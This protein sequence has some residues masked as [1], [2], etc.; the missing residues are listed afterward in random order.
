MVKK[1]DN[2]ELL[3]AKLETSS[4]SMD[5]GRKLGYS[6]LD[7]PKKLEDHFY[8]VAAF[9]LPYY[10]VTG[11]KTD[12]YRIRYLE[13]TK[14]GIFKQTNLKDRRYDQPSAEIPQLYIP[15]IL[16]KGKTWKDI[17]E[18]P[19]IPVIFTEGELKAACATKHGLPTLA[20]GGVWNF[21]SK[22]AGLLRLPI[23]NEM[24]FKGRTVFI[25][26]D[27]DSATNPQVLH[28]QYKFAEEIFAL[29]AN[30]VVV[31]IPKVADKKHGID[32]YIVEYGLDE[33]K[34][35]LTDDSNHTEFAFTRELLK[36]NSEIAVVTRPVSVVHFE[37]GQLLNRND[38]AMLYAN[39]RM[40]KQVLKQPTKKELADNPD[41]EKTITY[42]EVSTFDEWIKWEGRSSVWAPVYEPGYPVFTVDEDGT[43][44]FNT[45]KGW[46]AVPKKGD[47]SLWHWLLKNVFKN[48]EAAHIK[49]FEQ[50]CAYPLQNPG[51]KMFSCPILFGRV[52]GT[53]KSLLGLTLVAIYGENGAEVNDTQLEDERNVFAAQKQFVLANEVTGS[54]KRAMIGRLRNLITQHTVFINKK[55]EPDY[56]IRDTINYL[57][58]SNLLDAVYM[59]DDERRFFVHE[60]LGPRLVDVSVSKV[61]AYDR[62]LKSGE[63]ASAVFAH[64]L[65]VDCSDFDPAAPAPDTAS[66]SVMVDA[67]L[68]ELD[69]WCFK[70]KEDPDTCLRTGTNIIPFGLFRV[71]DLLDIYVGDGKLKRPY[72]KTMAN[73]L[74]KAGFDKAAGGNSCPTRDGK[75]NLWTVRDLTLTNKSAIL[76]GK[77]YDE[78]R[79]FNSRPKKFEK[80]GK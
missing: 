56:T 8:A 1:N 65:T 34:M 73:S 58:T 39:A 15:H 44:S 18:N 33:F 37:T 54:D 71:D 28:A 5:D 13:T 48:A 25:V 75:I 42:K 3:R 77:R 12:F 38:A 59:E 9:V 68:S 6:V 78:E 7:N 70:L 22:K 64:L 67:S 46:G 29:G 41:A 72:S 62:W 40:L 55:Y 51:V 27:S 26:F 49:W 4:L 24:K 63:A 14:K 57:L 19:A 47:V 60:V 76:V 2:T 66:K 61:Q 50:W 21:K 69:A 31:N 43:R 17:F 36:L 80:G 23:F 10:D 79:D 16:P 45:W 32:D 20:L 53:G 30:P 35:L 11:K 52:K 74:R